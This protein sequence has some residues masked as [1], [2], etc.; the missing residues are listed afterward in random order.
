MASN[1]PN[2]LPLSAD[3]AIARLEMLLPPGS[4]ND[5]KCLVFRRAWQ[6]QGYSQIAEVAGYDADYLR[7]AGASLWRSLSQLMGCKV[8]KRSFR[9]VLIQQLPLLT[10]NQL[11]EDQL[12][13][14][15]LSASQVFEGELRESPTESEGV[16]PALLTEGSIAQIAIAP[17]DDELK[18]GLQLT[19]EPVL[20]EQTR[21]DWDEAPDVSRFYGR[22]VELEQLQ[23]MI[24]GGQ[25]RLSCRLVTLLGMGGMGKTSLAAKMAQQLK[26]EF[27]CVVWRSLRNAPPL[28]NLLAD[29]VAFLSQQALPQGDQR[30]LMELLRQQRC[31]VVLD[32]AETLLKECVSGHYRS[33]YEDYGHFFRTL[34]E[35]DHGSCIVVTSREKL[36]QLSLV[37]GERSPVRSL[38]IG[39][40]SSVTQAL[41][42]DL[43]LEGTAQE[44][45]ALCQACGYSPLAL[46]LMANQI[47][48]LFSGSIA[49][50]LAEGVFAFDGVRRLL[51]EHIRR[52]TSLEYAILAWLAI[53]RDWTDLA[54][55]QADLV[56]AVPKFQLLTALSALRGRSLVEQR[57]GCY[58]LQGAVMEYMTETIIERV[59]QEMV[60]GLNLWLQANPCSASM[61]AGS[62]PKPLALEGFSLLSASAG[63]HLSRSGLGNAPEQSPVGPSQSVEASSLG[64]GAGGISLSDRPSMFPILHSHALMKATARE[65]IRESQIALILSPISN[66][67]AQWAGDALR[68][69]QVIQFLLDALRCNPIGQSGYCAGNLIDLALCAGLDMTGMNFSQLTLRQAYLRQAKLHDV[70]FQS[71]RFVDSTFTQ[72]FGSI[73]CLDF[74]P[75]GQYVALGDALGKIQ[76]WSLVTGQLQASYASVDGRIHCLAFSPDGQCLA[77]GSD[78]GQVDLWELSTGQRLAQLRGHSRFVWSLAWGPSGRWL[79]TGGGDRSLRLWSVESLLPP[80]PNGLRQ[81][82]QADDVGLVCPDPER[83][84]ELRRVGSPQL[85]DGA[86]AAAGSD[87]QHLLRV[88][89][90]SS[91][92]IHA[93][94]IRPQGDMLVSGSS[95]GALRLWDVATG[96]YLGVLLGHERWVSA[97][98][99]SPDGETIASASHDGT[100]R[101]WES[102]SGELIRI[103]KGHTGP[104]S[105]L[106]FSPDGCWL[107]SASRDQ[108]LR[109]WDVEWGTCCR[110]FTGHQGWIQAMAFSP[111]GKTLASGGHDQTLRLWDTQSGSRLSLLQGYAANMRCVDWHPDGERL[112]SCAGDDGLWFWNVASLGATV[113]DEPSDAISPSDGSSRHPGRPAPFLEKVHRC[114]HRGL[115][116]ARWS[117]DGQAVITASKDH[118]VR[119]V[120][121]EL[122]DRSITFGSVSLPPMGSQSGLSGSTHGSEAHQGWVCT[123]CLSP[124]GALVASGSADNNIHLWDRL[125][126]RQVA[127]LSGHSSRVCTVSFS[128]DGQ[129]IFSG[130]ADHSIRQW[131]RSGAYVRPFNGHDDW[132]TAVGACPHDY[133]L[134]SAGLDGQLK[135]WLLETGACLL[136]LACHDRPITDLAWRQDGQQ[137]ATCS[138]D[139]SIH[140]WDW[141][142]LQSCL[143]SSRKGAAVLTAQDFPRDSGYLRLVGH[144][145]AVWSVTFSPDGSRLATA[146][147]DG[148]C[149]IWDTRTGDCLATLRPPGPYEG[150]K[151]QDLQGLTHAQL[152]TLCKLGASM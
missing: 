37:E 85:E 80:D 16:T 19:A 90:I 81:F 106:A 59:L 111:D 69:R 128:T 114:D 49:S 112:V 61:I 60:G 152:E 88:I 66:Y 133:F 77:S 143:E 33:G 8:T 118:Q 87:D 56:P 104:V 67:L 46:K 108:S 3:E 54:T 63:A 145:A 70:D 44:R 102:D 131:T 35:V 95:D 45:E 24:L 14:S 132:V 82:T 140:L 96:Q 28:E 93:V 40:S 92:W 116:I 72:V 94:A 52:L 100:V 119:V 68:F 57:D 53:N 147:E 150:M 47:Q 23:A 91:S 7:E 139:H 76:L 25:G 122:G 58:G 50:F 123:L 51:D 117:P 127:R 126:G 151:L 18:P 107:A 99:F 136:S 129:S 48:E 73:L 38:A 1:L 27:D 78:Q 115:W 17:G 113:R 98:V 83:A 141:T 130:G 13:D 42:R 75:D 55:L 6:G 135:L 31:L 12:P 79:V 20:P 125:S 5:V 39:G 146:S 21:C 142:I 149:K 89:N 30:Q 74:S 86:G 109:L 110:A 4:L 124:D 138:L 101:L 10:D 148:T 62:L 64:G 144:E 134:A 71:S 2:H 65:Y 97:V 105:H 43:P 32:N 9:M 41:A 120:D 121:A 26:K 103:L 34:G 36:P 15:Q 22:E 137:L 11:S 84:P 29:L